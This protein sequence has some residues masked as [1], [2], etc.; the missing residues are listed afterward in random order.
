MATKAE[1]LTT[2]LCALSESE[3]QVLITFLAVAVKGYGQ[4]LRQYCLMIHG[5]AHFRP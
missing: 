1:T 4:S 2:L 3:R 5:L